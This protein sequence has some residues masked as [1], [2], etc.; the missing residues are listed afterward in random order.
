M[1]RGSFEELFLLPASSNHL[2][3]NT[4]RE[5]LMEDKQKL[6]ISVKYHIAQI[7]GE[8]SSVSETLSTFSATD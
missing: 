3:M 1:L 7:E 5:S 4:L 6:L 8:I 2:F